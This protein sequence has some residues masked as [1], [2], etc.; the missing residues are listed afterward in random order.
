[1]AAVPTKKDP[2]RD[3]R[4]V[5]ETRTDD[6][7]DDDDTTT[8]ATKK[9]PTVDDIR[10]RAS[11][12]DGSGPPGAYATRK[13]PV[14]VTH[15]RMQISDGRYNYD[16]YGECKRCHCIYSQGW[17]GGGRGGTSMQ[18]WTLYPSGCTDTCW[19]CL[20]SV[21]T[22]ERTTADN[23]RRQVKAD[24]EKRI[25]DDRWRASMTYTLNCLLC[26]GTP[27]TIVCYRTPP[28]GRRTVTAAVCDTCKA[29][30]ASIVLP[31]PPV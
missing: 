28:H 11:G 30:V 23:H 6:D 10:K 8:D 19:H 1:M 15:E 25:R 5:E 18:T 27:T 12:D 2:F 26:V 16:V 9:P 17:A 3:D 22:D 24:E 31:T 21:T 4:E 20:E 7:D 29:R 14:S 13:E